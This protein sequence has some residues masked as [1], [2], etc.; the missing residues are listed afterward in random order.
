MKIDCLA[1]WFAKMN[2]C[3]HEHG[4]FYFNTYLLKFLKISFLLIP[5]NTIADTV[6]DV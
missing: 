2:L 1:N 3:K 6:L 4:L 5:S